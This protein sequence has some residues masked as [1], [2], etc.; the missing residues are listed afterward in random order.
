[1]EKTNQKNDID[2]YMEIF[3]DNFILAI[4]EAIKKHKHR[5]IMYLRFGLFDE[6]F[7]TL[8][9]IGEMF[10]LSRERIRQIIN[11]SIKK[12]L[13][14]GN[15][16]FENCRYFLDTI[17]NWVSPGCENELLNT[18]I[19]VM[20]L[21]TFPRVLII[22]LLCRLCFHNDDRF[23]EKEKAVL[24][25]VTTMQN[26]L[27]ESKAEKEKQKKK[28]ERIFKQVIWQDYRSTI[29]HTQLKNIT[30]KRQVNHRISHHS[31]SFYSKKNGTDI[32]YES[33]LEYNFCLY[34][35]EVDK[36]IGYVQQPVKIKYTYKN[37][38]FTYYPDFLVVLEDKSGILVEIKTRNKMALFQNLIK[39][40]ALQQFC[41]IKGFGYL[42]IEKN[43]SLSDYILHKVDPIKKDQF[44]K[45]VQ[46]K[47]IDWI[48]YKK[49][50]NELGITT[51][52]FI[53]L[54]INNNLK[55]TLLPF[56]VSKSNS[57]NT[58]FIEKHLS[59]MD[60]KEFID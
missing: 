24:E 39:Y 46:Q 28:F 2:N 57:V 16:K 4:E 50:R 38:I 30:P 20:R 44:L 5:E 6:E 15:I 54:V 42:V 55:W 41:G 19:L 7:Y 17:Y 51:K 60:K 25:Y 1:M 12:I 53:S 29:S 3:Q 40:K 31:G 18:A 37:Q 10:S 8:Q 11:S 34:L 32:E 59:L 33:S 22:N 26:S 47:D 52:D 27:T 45:C 36:V 48:E 35:E 13:Y 43:L 21:E 49:I 23:K 56:S 14:R 58:D 9:E